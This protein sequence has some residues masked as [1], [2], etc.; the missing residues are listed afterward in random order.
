MKL[1]HLFLQISLLVGISAYAIGCASRPQTT[2][3]TNTTV[4]VRPKEYM[5]QFANAR[6]ESIPWQASGTLSIATK[7]FSVDVRADISLFP[8]RGLYMS[9][10]P[11][12]FVEVARIYLLPDQFILID[13]YDERYFAT[14]YEELNK[15]LKFPISYSLIES[16]ILGEAVRPFE[17][18][19]FVEGG[20][21]EV[22]PEQYPVAV[23]YTLNDLLRPHKAVTTPAYRGFYA[24]IDYN[25]YAHRMPGALPTNMKVQIFKMG[26]LEGSVRYINRSL[27]REVEA[28][29]KL[30]PYIPSGYRQLSAQEAVRMLR[31]LVN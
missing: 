20:K 16:L 10:R 4:A 9:L 25:E 24:E 23:R 30:V 1:S 2:N 17:R 28:A 8:E 13:K 11:L 18:M 12:P 3:S 26:S 6:A 22:Q 7:G 29:N 31:Q 19:T 27:K 14:S 21:I 5:Q 15:E